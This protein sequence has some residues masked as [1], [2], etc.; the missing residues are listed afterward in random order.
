MTRLFCVRDFEAIPGEAL[1]VMDGIL[2]RTIN[3]RCRQHGIDL[4]LYVVQPQG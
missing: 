2:L 4:C 1:E 3:R